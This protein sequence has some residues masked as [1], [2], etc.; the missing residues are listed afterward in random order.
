MTN[1]RPVKLFVSHS[2]RSQPGKDRLVELVDALRSGDDA[3]DVLYDAEQIEATTRWRDVIDAMLAECHAA[4]VLVTPDALD[5]AWVL[6]EATL[7]RARYDAE[8][9]KQRLLSTFPLLP[10]LVDV[11]RD[12]LKAH[13]LWHPLDLAA[14]QSM[15]GDDPAAIAAT[16][17]HQLT[18]VRGSLRRS[19]LERLA[20]DIATVLTRTSGMQRLEDV[21]AYLG[22]PGAP[23]HLVGGAERLAHAIARWTL[24]LHPPSLELVADAL[25]QLG[26]VFPAEDAEEI[27]SILGPLWVELDAAAW[28]LR[29][30]SRP[31]G[32]RDV[33]IG[34]AHPNATI[35]D[36]AARAHMPARKPTLLLLHGMT[37]RPEDIVAELFDVGKRKLKYLR[38]RT[39]QELDAYF[40]QD[41]RRIFVAVP[42][43]GDE[44][45]AR[46]QADY[47]APTFIFYVGSSSPV[48]VPP[49]GVAMVEP[50]LDP[51]F[52]DSVRADRDTAYTMFG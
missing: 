25:L 21:I 5:S 51:G 18:L 16:I 30:A 47:P 45:V 39:P 52:E 48:P 9:Q 13:P 19:P 32:C 3:V 31:E 15:P 46:L 42:L 27:L 50:A 8:Y 49:P 44:V 6:T 10:I 29:A 23:T 17:K 28:I 38:E 11:T 40:K 26:N 34:C 20:G 14:I 4:V 36:Y 41:A 22:T 33:V 2:S 12:D 7:L 43:P 35:E 24:G 1:D 37:G